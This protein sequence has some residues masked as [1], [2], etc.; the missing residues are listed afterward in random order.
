VGVGWAWAASA[1]PREP[2]KK[3]T[4][5]IVAKYSHVNSLVD[6][7]RHQTCLHCFCDPTSEALSS[8]S[9]RPII[10]L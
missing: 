7:I 1:E 2:K 10:D 9:I 5:Y 4:I 3:K 6:I 8:S